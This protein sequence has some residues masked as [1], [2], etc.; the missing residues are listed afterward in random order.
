MVAAAA[1]DLYTPFPT[2]LTIEDGVQSSEEGSTSDIHS[3]VF[4]VPYPADVRYHLNHQLHVP[5]A[6]TPLVPAPFDAR[7]STQ[8]DLSI[9]PPAPHLLGTLQPPGSATMQQMLPHSHVDYTRIHHPVL[10]LNIGSPPL[11]H[12]PNT[13]SPAEEYSFN[14]PQSRFHEQQQLR[15]SYAAP[16]SSAPG[17]IIMSSY[18]QKPQPPQRASPSGK[19]NMAGSSSPGP[20]GPSRPRREAS[21]VV[22]ACRQCRGRKIRCDSTRPVCN[23]CTRR[24]NECEYDAV[25]KRRGPDKR[26]GT[27][28]RSCKKR[29]SEADSS[30]GGNIMAKKRRKVDGDHDGNLVSFQTKEGAM[31]VARRNMLIAKAEDA[32][33]VHLPQAPPHVLETSMPPRGIASEAIYPKQDVLPQAPRHSP[34]HPFSIS[35]QHEDEQP[36]ILPTL[37]LE[38]SR[39]TWWDNLLNTY[40]PTRPESMK[41]IFDDLDFL[42]N[43]SSYWLFFLNRDTFFENLRDP[44]R[45]TLIQ[46]SLVLSALA[47]ANLMQASELERGSSGRRIALALRDAAQLSLEAACNAR[48][49]DFTLAEAA[50]ILALFESSCHPQYSPERAEQSLQFVDRIIRGLS[51]TMIDMEDGDVCM[52]Q[53]ASPPCVYLPPTYEAPRRCN[54]SPL[55]AANAVSPVEHNY[56]YQTSRPAWDPASPEELRK[57]ECRRICWSA[58]NLVASYTA[59]CAAF[60]QEPIEL[61]LTEPSNYAILFPGEAYARTQ[62]SQVSPKDSV[63]ALYCR[64]MLLWT[65]CIRQ[66]EDTW[67]MEDRAT[68]AARAFVETGCIQDALEMHC[69]NADN[70]LMYLTR[71]YIYN[72]RM[73]ITY[74]LRRRLQDIDNTQPR[75][76][77]KREAL[78]WLYYQDQ[79]AQRVKNSVRELGETQGHLL[80]RRPFQTW[81]Y[82]S[83]ISICLALWNYDGTLKHALE[84]AKSLLIPLD[85]L[86]V[87][88]PCQAQHQRCQELRDRITDACNIAELPGPLPTNVTLPLV[89]QRP[90][91]RHLQ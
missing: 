83:Q 82:S 44:H 5:D 51:L 65:S 75:Q 24:G 15:A 8:H 1:I 12:N 3:P 55:L 61:Y 45:R 89:L 10:D 67:T 62:P 71:E 17:S 18:E 27:R 19:S 35:M 85:T 6:S 77:N 66:R 16:P 49:L 70:S 28:Q 59:Q 25:P 80:T 30:D 39:R 40:A 37:S 34:F 47:M 73:T 29:P 4:E 9:Q 32:S 64:S 53:V 74:E 57:E 76:F 90:T 46:P 31:G 79:V 52:F 14:L 11:V 60:H 56:N 23:N 22:I 84:L 42:I 21:T 26:P 2:N 81:W 69:C 68:F 48:S 63:W 86:N 20:A 13:L 36:Q 7:Y 58:L 43:E 50:L 33:I 88:W 41:A 54:C 72:T 78:D 87:L 38:D 91:S